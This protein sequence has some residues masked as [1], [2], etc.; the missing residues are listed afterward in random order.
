MRE[1]LIEQRKTQKGDLVFASRRIAKRRA[2]EGL[3][4]VKKAFTVACSEAG[5]TDFHFQDLRHTFAR[6]LGDAV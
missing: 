3:V 1:V 2:G 5:I 6:R 4:D